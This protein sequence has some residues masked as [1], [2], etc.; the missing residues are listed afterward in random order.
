MKRKIFYCLTALGFLAMSG[1]VSET[2][3]GSAHIFGYELWVPI[4]VLLGGIVAVPAG[5]MLRTA[6]ERLGWVL[7]ILGPVAALLIAP[8]LFV[9]C[10]VVDDTSYTNRSGIWGMTSYH[11][12]KF[13]DLNQ[14]R[15]TEE[16]ERGS[17]GRT[18]IKCYLNCDLKNGTTL[19]IPA[20]NNDVSEAASLQFLK[21]AKER[22]IPIVDATQD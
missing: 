4:A 11:E 5:W 14:I 8:S 22:G 20:D 10:A 13:A 1:C 19:K 16:E 6:T 3:K 21:T 7:M 2:T 9:D 12:V 15:V 17:R 18:T